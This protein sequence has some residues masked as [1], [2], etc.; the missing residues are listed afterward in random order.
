MISS[1]GVTISVCEPQK[2]Q[3]KVGSYVSYRVVTNGLSASAVSV[4]RRYS[5][6][7]W[8]QK[9]LARTS[10]GVIVPSLPVKGLIG[11]FAVDFVEE[12]Q[13]GL[14][15]FLQR[16]AAHPELGSHQLFV[17][18]L[19]M[20]DA[21][22][23]RTMTDTKAGKPQTT[24]KV[25]SWFENISNQIQNSGKQVTLEKSPQDLEVDGIMSYIELFDA[26][27]H[28]VVY[29]EKQWNL[30]NQGIAAVS[31]EMGKTY[32]YLETEQGDPMA[33]SFGNL[34]KTTT[35]EA[36]NIVEL[37]QNVQV[38]SVEPF[39][40]YYR[41]VESIKYSHKKREEKKAVYINALTEVEVKQKAYNAVLGQA[42]KEDAANQRQ[43]QVY[44]AQ[45]KADV[46]KTDFVGTTDRFLKEFETFKGLKAVD[47]KSTME[48]FVEMQMAYHKQS[49]QLWQELLPLLQQTTISQGS[50]FFVPAPPPPPLNSNSGGGGG[51]GYNPYGYGDTE[52][53]GV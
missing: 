38:Q 1:S 50:A 16:I 7:E 5:E 25:G 34:G 29:N 51:G 24:Q 41:S 20:D 48:K 49:Q 33:T 21:Q 35:T 28:K 39:M 36:N 8:L 46:A 53:V 4:N 45:S 30:V 52:N 9:E 11:S 18:F 40:E 26:N 14:E 44:E 27:V 22:F 42:G 47:F 13:R 10:P 32:S 6:F 17:S 12:R 43:Q 19:Q 2:L 31:Q 23:Q 15:K 3:D 37:A